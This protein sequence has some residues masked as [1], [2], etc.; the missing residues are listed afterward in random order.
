MLHFEN[1]KIKREEL[2][3]E[4]PSLELQAGK[5]IA[6]IGANGVGKSTLFQQL[7]EGDLDGTVTFSSKNW[8]EFSLK[9]RAKII[10]LVDNKFQGNGNLTTKDY[11]ELGRIPHT[12]F[13]G[14]LTSEDEQIISQII[15]EFCLEHLLHKWIDNL[16]DGERQR[17]S[18]AR[19]LIQDT[20]IVLLD[21]PTAF[22]DYPTKKAVMQT[23]QRIVKE[24]NKLVLISTHDLDLAHQYCDEFLFV[25][26]NIKQLIRVETQEN[27]DKFIITLFQ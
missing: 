6:L 23:L 25:D 27:L 7:I 20:P 16:S 17:T 24:K 2:L 11:L 12:G 15:D 8:K 19:A 26:S 13:F 22:L 5:F 4:I 1:C 10:A 21:E 3:Y 9:E 18:I 14:K